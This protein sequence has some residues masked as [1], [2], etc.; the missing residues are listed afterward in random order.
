M[1]AKCIY[2]VWERFAHQASTILRTFENL[3]K[4]RS[5]HICWNVRIWDHTLLT[6]GHFSATGHIIGPGT[7]GAHETCWLASLPKCW[8]FEQTD[9]WPFWKTSSGYFQSLKKG[10][11]VGFSNFVEKYPPFTTHPREKT[12][13]IFFKIVNYHEQTKQDFLGDASP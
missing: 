3:P 5:V 1:G 12:R 8:F 4:S 7:H 10:V 2:R 11:L 6:A 9:N 13:S